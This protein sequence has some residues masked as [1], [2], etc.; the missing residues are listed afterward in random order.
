MCVCVCG[1]DCKILLSIS[2]IN[3]KRYYL[4]DKLCGLRVTDL[5]YYFET[6]CFWVN[7][8][9]FLEQNLM[10]HISIHFTIVSAVGDPVSTVLWVVTNEICCNSC[11]VGQCMSQQS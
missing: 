7:A 2:R 11:L 6:S 10:E 8:L 9:Y 3:T 1:R 4:L 5:E